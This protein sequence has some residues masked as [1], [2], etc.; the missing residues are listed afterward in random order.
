MKNSRPLNDRRPSLD[1]GFIDVWIQETV[2]LMYLLQSTLLEEATFR[3]QI[4]EEEGLEA[5]FLCSSLMR[6]DSQ[7]MIIGWR[8]HLVIFIRKENLKNNILASLPFLFWIPFCL[9]AAIT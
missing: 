7:K 3:G 6:P 2:F 4:L 9:V 5:R 1:T 8:P